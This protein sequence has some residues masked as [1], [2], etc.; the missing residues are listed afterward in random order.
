M[1]VSP[2]KSLR[3]CLG[4][5]HVHFLFANLVGILLLPP[6]VLCRPELSGGEALFLSVSHAEVFLLSLVLPLALLVQ[7]AHSQ[8]NVSVR[9]VTVGVVDGS[10][11]AYP[12]CHKLFLDKFLQQ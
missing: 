5:N 7:R 1:L 12:V 3:I 4:R 8:Q 11:D 6:L 9:I 2:D 10:V